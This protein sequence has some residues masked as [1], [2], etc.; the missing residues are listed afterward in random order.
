MKL[1]WTFANTQNKYR[2]IPKISPGAYIFQRPFLRGLFLEGLINGGKFA[3]QNR[4]G[5]YWLAYS[6]KE[7]YVSNLQKVFTETRLEDVDL[8]KTWPY[9]YFVHMGWGNQGQKWKGTT[10]T[11][12]NCDFLTTNTWQTWKSSLA[13]TKTYMLLYRFCF[14]LFCIWGHFQSTNPQGL[15]FGGAI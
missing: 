6:W 7:I 5:L 12:I 2:K 13:N 8:S 11:A 3:F 15:T 4:L 14:V 1:I 10:Q 9:E